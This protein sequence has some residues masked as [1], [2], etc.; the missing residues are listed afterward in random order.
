VPVRAQ[1]SD[2]FES[3]RPAS[4]KRMLGSVTYKGFDTR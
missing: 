3:D 1:H 4:F 2:S